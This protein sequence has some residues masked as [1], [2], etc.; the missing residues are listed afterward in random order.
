M[1][2]DQQEVPM[3]LECSYCGSPLSIDM[4]RSRFDRDAALLSVEWDHICTMPPPIISSQLE[5]D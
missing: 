3:T 5:D 4:G 2:D 1:T